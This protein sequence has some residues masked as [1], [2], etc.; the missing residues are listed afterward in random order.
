MQIDVIENKQI[1][2]HSEKGNALMWFTQVLLCGRHVLCF[3]LQRLCL[4]WWHHQHPQVEMFYYCLQL[5]WS[6][7]AMTLENFQYSPQLLWYNIW[8]SQFCRPHI[9][10]NRSYLILSGNCKRIIIIAGFLMPLV[11]SAFTSCEV[12]IHGFCEQTKRKNLIL[13]IFTRSINWTYNEKVC[14][15]AVRAMQ[16]SKS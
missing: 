12:K 3:W 7:S 10:W 4:Q 14:F 1:D 5:F 8:P 6:I 2:E 15:R 11:I 13:H 9:R 16:N